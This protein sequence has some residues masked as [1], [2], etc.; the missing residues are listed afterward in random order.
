MIR[1]WTLVGL[2]ALMMSGLSNCGAYTPSP[3]S[4][5]NLSFQTVTDAANQTETKAEQE[6]T[7]SA[8]DTVC[9]GTDKTPEQSSAQNADS[10]KGKPTVSTGSEETEYPAIRTNENGDVCLP[11]V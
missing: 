1:I 4:E 5:E 11:E 6:T 9:S 7:V 2:S 8:S 3:E 10:D